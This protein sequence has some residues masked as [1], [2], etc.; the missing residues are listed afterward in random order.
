MASKRK[1]KFDH[2]VEMDM[3]P[4]IDIVFLLIV[5]FMVVTELSV[6]QAVVILPVAS[7]AKVEEP[8]PDQIIL[9][10]NV[11]FDKDQKQIVQLM[12]GS[13]LTPE[14]LVTVL[15]GEAAAHGKYEDNPNNPKVKL[16][17]LHVT[18]RCDQGADAG[19]IHKIFS[20]CQ[21]AGIYQVSC[22]AINDRLED[23]YLDQ[24]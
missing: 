21:K 17:T 6:Q 22:S 20:A 10:V 13:P 4:M 23:P 8:Q 12:N 15:K 7:E 19:N 3:T 16:S 2:G 9:V 5:F 1:K 14:E 18:I 11:S 24:P